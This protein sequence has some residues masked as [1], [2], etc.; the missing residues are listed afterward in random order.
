VEFGVICIY[1]IKSAAA[2]NHDVVASVVARHQGREVNRQRHHLNPLHVY[3]LAYLSGLLA[4]A[5]YETQCRTRMVQVQELEL[6][7]ADGGSLA[8]SDDE[9]IKFH[10]WVVRALVQQVERLEEQ[11]KKCVAKVTDQDK[12]IA[13]LEA[14]H[15]GKASL[16]NDQELSP[17]RTP[18][19]VCKWK[20]TVR[21]PHLVWFQNRLLNS[22]H[23]LHSH[24]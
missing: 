20:N 2:G 11:L 19:C 13:E 4:N 14:N 8:Q 15:S 23:T 18:A 6:H 24:M 10:A 16:A 5:P 22:V 9:S 17:V 3:S 21:D 7:L 12:R 1:R